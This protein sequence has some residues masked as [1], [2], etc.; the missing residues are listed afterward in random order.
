MTR[1]MWSGTVRAL[2]FRE[3]VKAARVAGC[4][5]LSISPMS[6]DLWRAAGISTR[7][8]LAMAADEGVRVT[9]LD[10]I[11]RWH[12]NWLPDN[13]DPQLC[14]LGVIGYD[15]DDFFRIADALE[16]DTISAMVTGEAGRSDL[17]R[18]T[19][20]FAALCDR[21]GRM[22]LRCDLEFVPMWALPDLESAW[23]VLDNADRANSG[24]TFDLWHYLRGNP[25]PELLSS[26][27]GNKIASVQ[28]TDGLAQPF[29]N[30]LLVDCL[31]HRALPGKGALPIRAVLGQL[32]AIGALDNIV[33]FEVFSSAMDSLDA[34]AL[35]EACRNS[36]ADLDV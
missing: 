27:P 13:M 5:A 1:M 34:Q 17:D 33:G 2:P 36:L 9:H 35:G 18:M 31:M 12:D 20:D 4:T 8:M 16:V 26:I 30:D 15:V 11:T 14:P 7:D 6:Y 10:P 23:Y 3:Q 29:G 32:G 25:D 28:L 22:G 24:L 19:E 21:A